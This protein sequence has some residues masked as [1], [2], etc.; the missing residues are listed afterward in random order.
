[1]CNFINTGNDG[2][3]RR[4][5]ETLF[6]CKTKGVKQYQWTVWYNPLFSY[7]LWSCA[8]VIIIMVIAVVP[9]LSHKGKCSAHYEIYKNV[10]I[11]KTWKIIS[12]HIVFPSNTPHPPS[13]VQH[14]ATQHTTQH[15]THTH[16]HTHTHTQ[17]NTTQH[18]TTQH[19]TTQHNTT[20]TH[21]HTHTHTWWRSCLIIL[22]AREQVKILK[23]TKMS[24]QEFFVSATTEEVSWLVTCLTFQLRCIYLVIQQNNEWCQCLCVIFFFFFFFKGEFNL[25]SHVCM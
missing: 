7:F 10:Y 6:L 25:N 1:M 3:P 24:E 18:N 23:E 21:T 19:N 13:A 2:L 16:T 17:H 5:E 8:G 20:H 15:N 22:Q 11:G 14:N 4:K 12:N 9:Y